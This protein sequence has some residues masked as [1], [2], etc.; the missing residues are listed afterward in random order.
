M[1]GP[2]LPSDYRP[3]L[4]NGLGHFL[5]WLTLLVTLLAAA[6]SVYGRLTALEAREDESDV[7][8]HSMMDSLG[9]IEQLLLE[10]AVPR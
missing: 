1:I 9:R 2:A 4:L 7:D 5:G 3:P 8:R 10:R 6:F